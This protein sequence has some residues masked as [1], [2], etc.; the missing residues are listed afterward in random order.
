L[1]GHGAKRRISFF[2]RL[3][4]GG[5][6]RQLRNI[7]RRKRSGN[8]M[9]AGELESDSERQLAA[10]MSLPWRGRDATGRVSGKDLLPS[11]ALKTVR[12]T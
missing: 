1:C 12:T 5:R 8:E 3:G 9:L 4:G 6:Q 7:F 10:A 2:E 11:S